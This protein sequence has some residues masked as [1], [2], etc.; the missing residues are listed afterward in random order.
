[1][2]ALYFDIV[3][4]R[5]YCSG[6]GSPERRGA[7]TAMYEILSALAR[8]VAPVMPFT[9]D[10]IC[11]RCPDAAPETAFFSLTFRLRALN[12]RTPS[13]SSAGSA[14]GGSEPRSR[15]RSKNVESPARS[16]TRSKPVCGSRWHLRKPRHSARSVRSSWPRHTSYPTSSFA[17]TKAS[18]RRLSRCCR[19]RREVW[20]L[21]ELAA[22]GWRAL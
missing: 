16:D 2:S 4:D 21:L 15:R 18:R 3:K 9:A 19:D 7:Q 22:D 5:V 11:A 20:A 10:E 8:I 17:P 12:G 13:S 14:C 1:M 6:A